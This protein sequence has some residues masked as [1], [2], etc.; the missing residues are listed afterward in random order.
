MLIHLTQHHLQEDMSPQSNKRGNLKS[1]IGAASSGSLS[2]IVTLPMNMDAAELVFCLS[3]Y[4]CAG[5]ALK[6]QQTATMHQ[7]NGR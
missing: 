1:C 5:S 6:T 4:S 3:S 7:T 2:S